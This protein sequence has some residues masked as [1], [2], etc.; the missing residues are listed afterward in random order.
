MLCRVH[1]VWSVKRE[2]SGEG[3]REGFWFWM[4]WNPRAEVLIYIS[5]S[6]FLLVSWFLAAPAACVFIFFPTL[7]EVFVGKRTVTVSHSW[8]NRA[9]ASPGTTSLL[10][11][12]FS[13]WNNFKVG[14]SF[15]L[16]EMPPWDSFDAHAYLLISQYML[17]FLLIPRWSPLSWLKKNSGDLSVPLKRM[18]QWNTELTLLRRSLAVASRLEV[19]SLKLDQKKR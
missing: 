11:L 2:N 3:G 17:P 16:M 13:C 10:Q 12:F 19:G 8:E 9:A 5:E 6:W 15:K 18:W 7:E 14:K 4:G 1:F